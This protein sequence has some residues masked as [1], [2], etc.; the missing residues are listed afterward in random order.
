MM[1]SKII[2]IS[3]SSRF[4][5]V[6]AVCAWILERDENTIV[7]GLH[8]LP[9][10]YCDKLDHLAEHQGV[11]DQMDELH[12]RKIDLADELFVVNIYNYIGESTKREIEYAKKKNIPIRYYMDDPIGIEVHKRIK[13]VG[14]IAAENDRL[15]TGIID[16]KIQQ[17]QLI[18]FILKNAAI[19]PLTG[20]IV[21]IL[22]KG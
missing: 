4:C 6:I 2:V 9:N 11:A 18:E 17:T 10:W 12:L 1:K 15:K 14:E 7:M 13:L 20:D 5:D 16:L 19:L 21:E 8:L 3:G 22:N